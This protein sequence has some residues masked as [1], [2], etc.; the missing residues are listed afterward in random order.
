MLG[1]LLKEVREPE[2]SVESKKCFFNYLDFWFKRLYE[3]YEADVNGREERG[4]RIETNVLIEV[5]KN[6][7]KLKRF[8]NR[9]F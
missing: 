9:D 5:S 6:F 1:E 2:E 8:L 7:S 4:E 3:V